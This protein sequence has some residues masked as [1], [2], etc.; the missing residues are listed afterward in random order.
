MLFLEIMSNCLE[1]FTSEHIIPRDRIAKIWHALFLVRIWRQFILKHPSL[2]LQHNF[3]SL[4][5]FS[6]IEQNAHSLVWII[7]FLRKNNLPHLFV[8][9]LFNSQACEGFYR[10]I[11]SLCPTYCMMATCSV[12]Q[13]M[14]RISSIHLLNDICNDTEGDFKF[15]IAH[16]AAKVA[17]TKKLN[18]DLPSEDE[19]YQTIL[20]S[21]EQAIN[22]SIEIGLID[23]R[24]KS[25]QLICN[26]KPCESDINKTH[27]CR[28]NNRRNVVLHRNTV[29][30]KKMC[31]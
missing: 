22:V 18:F 21:E 3:M 17:H 23:K 30:Q 16:R 26:I 20:K 28:S 15:P 1:A 8:P 11:R 13:A 12:K 5:C 2:T 31:C 10:Q 19:I 4:N 9:M 27:F 25:S 14:S 24:A 6:C 7:L 29:Y